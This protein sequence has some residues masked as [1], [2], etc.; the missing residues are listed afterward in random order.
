MLRRWSACAV[1]SIGIGLVTL[2]MSRAGAQGGPRMP[3]DLARLPLDPAPGRF[4]APQA[5]VWAELKHLDTT[6]GWGIAQLEPGG[7]GYSFRLLPYATLRRFGEPGASAEDFPAGE[8]VLIRRAAASG[9]AGS[10]RYV[11]EIRDE[12]TEQ[13]EKGFS[14]RTTSQDTES[15]SFV[16]EPVSTADAVVGGKTTLLYGRDTVVVNRESPVYVFRTA[17][18]QKRWMSTGHREGGALMARYVLDQPSL[19]RFRR[20]QRQRLLARVRIHGATGDV[21]AGAR[22]IR[23]YPD[24]TAWAQRLKA[25]DE[26]R[27]ATVQSLGPESPVRVDGVEIRE[28]TAVVRLAAAAAAAGIVRLSPPAAKAIS[29]Q[30]EIRPLLETNCLPCH[31]AGTAQSGF[32]IS[33]PERLRAPGRRGIP[34]VPGKS[35]DSLLYLTMHGDRNPRMPPDRN[36]SEAELAVLRRWI[37]S[38]AVIDAAP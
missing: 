5:G 28:G 27:L 22:E 4:L 2:G 14:Y 9:Q 37:D 21:L 19:E 15:Y 10:E 26:L 3:G 18:G 30:W 6:L 34:V 38:G 16:V 11:A 20:Q 1:V 35:I 17:P 31:S 12:V 33:P 25:G 23:V 8:R 13:L 32:A 24:F 29:Y 36:Q 7:Q